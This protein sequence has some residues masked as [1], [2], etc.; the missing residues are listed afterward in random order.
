MFDYDP[1]QDNLLPCKD[2]GLAFQRGDILE[3]SRQIP[4]RGHRRNLCRNEQ[5]R[6]EMTFN[7]Y[8]RDP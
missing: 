7:E 2:I 6:Q 8:I 1:G 4:K 3:V 5:P